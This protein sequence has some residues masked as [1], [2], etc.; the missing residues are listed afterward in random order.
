VDLA[1]SGDGRALATSGDSAIRK[2]DVATGK[3]I[4]PPADGHQGTVEA[5]AFLPDSRALLTVGADHTLRRWD[6]AAEKESDRLPKVEQVTGR[7]CF[8][9]GG[10][11]LGLRVGPDVLLCDPST[12]KELR[13][14][15]FPA[16][17]RLA[18]LTPDG[19]ALA[20]YTGGKDRAL[21]VVDA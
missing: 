13:R 21:R 16:W 4:A 7:D 6:V 20:V 11:L 3:E 2:W 19:K 8:A 18:A 9:V 17:V 12:G 10:K 5:L 1:F 15:A 14:F